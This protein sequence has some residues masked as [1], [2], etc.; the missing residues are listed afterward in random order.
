MEVARVCERDWEWIEFF[1]RN[2]V[3]RKQA[4]FGNVVRP[5]LRIESEE[6]DERPWG[7]GER[8]RARPDDRTAEVEVVVLAQCVE[9][10]VQRRWRAGEQC[11]APDGEGLR[12]EEFFADLGGGGESLGEGL[13]DAFEFGAVLGVVRPVLR[14]EAVDERVPSIGVGERCIRREDSGPALWEISERSFVSA[15]QGGEAT[16]AG[17]GESAQ[18]N[19]REGRGGLAFTRC[20]NLHA[21][22]EVDVDSGVG[23]EREQV[24]VVVGSRGGGDGDFVGF[25]GAGGNELARPADGFDG[26]VIGRGSVD[27]VG[28]GRVGLAGV[29]LDV[30]C[31]EPV[32]GSAGAGYPAHLGVTRGALEQGPPAGGE[33]GEALDVDL[34]EDGRDVVLSSKRVF[35]QV[36]GAKLRCREFLQHRL[37]EG[38][39]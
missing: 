3:V 13:D 4:V 35:G 5:A 37:L 14:G 30:V 25:R 27:A 34:A 23:S 9:R 12:G 22:R 17:L 18:Q 11:F 28:L 16:Y 2:D 8:A 39:E 21:V 1:V 6:V 32:R 33:F 38:G 15:Q 29:Y 31:V 24:V 19:V 7:G 26:F 10:E 36:G 20:G